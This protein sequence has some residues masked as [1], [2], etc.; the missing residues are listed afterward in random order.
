MVLQDKE[1]FEEN[2][3]TSIKWKLN[4]KSIYTTF[5]RNK[6]RNH[7]L[8]VDLNDVFADRL[9]L[10]DSEKKWKAEFQAMTQNKFH[11]HVA[12]VSHISLLLYSGSVERST[13]LKSFMS[14]FH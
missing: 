12:S 11:L 8:W 13:G 14:Y 10:F 3:K 2:L 7:I 4:E 6:E 1:P 5:Q 9:I